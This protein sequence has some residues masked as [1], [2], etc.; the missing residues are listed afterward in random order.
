LGRPPRGPSIAP[1]H[2]EASGG[3]RPAPP[4]AC[5]AT[6]CSA[7]GW[8]Q[9]GGRNVVD[10]MR[11]TRC[12]GRNAA[13]RPA[14]WS[15]VVGHPSAGHGRQC[16]INPTRTQQ[17]GAAGAVGAGG[18]R[19]RRGH[20]AV[21]AEV[22]HGVREPCGC[23]GALGGAGAQSLL[24][25]L[26]TAGGGIAG[27]VVTDAAAQRVGMLWFVDTIRCQPKKSM[28]EHFRSSVPFGTLWEQSSASHWY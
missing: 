27:A 5:R 13:V 28:W 22:T 26:L 14:D 8:T 2:D 4:H 21:G 16:T 18:R 15:F 19:C 6:Q 9:R 3:N 7:P 23:P 24:G 12:G 1:P 17:R 20:E 10:A 11:W 25:G